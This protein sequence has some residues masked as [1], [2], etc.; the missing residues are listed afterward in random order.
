MYHVDGGSVFLLQFFGIAVSKRNFMKLTELGRLIQP[1]KH[2]FGGGGCFPLPCNW[3][4]L[5][6]TSEV[7]AYNLC[8]F[9]QNLM[10]N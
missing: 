6:I 3:N 10:K 7:V 9:S 1:Q 4:F 5:L 2:F 8:D